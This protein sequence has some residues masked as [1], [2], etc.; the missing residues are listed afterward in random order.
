MIFETIAAILFLLMTAVLWVPASVLLG[1]LHAAILLIFGILEIFTT[2]VRSPEDLF[3]VFSSAL[4]YGVGSLFRIPSWLWSW[5]KY[6]HPWWA[7]FI[8]LLF[9]VF[10]NNSKK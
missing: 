9:A 1:F 6:E 3:S 4:S 8:A 2:E 5:A 10:L 7:I